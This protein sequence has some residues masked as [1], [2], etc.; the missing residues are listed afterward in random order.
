M[1]SIDHGDVLTSAGTASAVDACLHLVRARLGAEAANR[2]ARSL[3][4]APHRGADRRNTSSA[5]CRRARTTIRFRA[6]TLGRLGEPLT[7]DR[8][9]AQA[10]LAANLLPA[11]HHPDE[12]AHAPVIL[13]MVDGEVVVAQQ[14]A[15]AGSGSAG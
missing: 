12:F 10:H 14:V 13:T 3:V 11:D 5:R 9:A 1:L 2:V 7:I 6:W 8:L 15:M 4:I